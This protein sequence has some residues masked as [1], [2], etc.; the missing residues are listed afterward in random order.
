MCEPSARLLCAAR[1]VSSRPIISSALA[2]ESLVSLQ[3]FDRQLFRGV[4]GAA[5]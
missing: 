4:S 1:G 3:G 2:A 5:S